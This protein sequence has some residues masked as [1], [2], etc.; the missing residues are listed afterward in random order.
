M[1][2]NKQQWHFKTPV[3][4]VSAYTYCLALKKSI[5]QN[6][7]VTGVWETACLSYCGMVGMVSLSTGPGDMMHLGCR[8]YFLDRTTD[9]KP[10]YQT[11][12][13]RKQ[14]SNKTQSRLELIGPW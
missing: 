14:Q 2:L 9:L 13:G 8:A 1:L 3:Q 11:G 6:A 4:S 12:E 10:T 7:Y 5:A